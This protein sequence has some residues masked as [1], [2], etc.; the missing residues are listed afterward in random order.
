M[1][2][3]DIH[4]LPEEVCNQKYDAVKE[5]Q[6]LANECP[7]ITRSTV[8][9]GSS[10]FGDIS[11]TSSLKFTQ[12]KKVAF[13]S[14]VNSER[15][16]FVDNPTLSPRPREKESWQFKRVIQSPGHGWSEGEEVEEKNEL[17]GVL[18]KRGEE[19]KKKKEGDAKMKSK[20]AKTKDAK[21]MAEVEKEES[22][23]EKNCAVWRLDQERNRKNGRKQLRD[24][25]DLVRLALVLALTTQALVSHFQLGGER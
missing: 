16:P 13:G 23:M 12:T 25:K 17:E 9:T 6:L 11:G 19:K 20:Q 21:E 10:Q 15:L 14:E 3:A 22:Q 24:A 18:A 4:V 7:I 5:S 1:G 2:Q 8:R